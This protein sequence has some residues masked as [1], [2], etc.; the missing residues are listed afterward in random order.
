MTEE[1]YLKI[2]VGEHN[3]SI[4]LDKEM[5]GT[6]TTKEIIDAMKSICPEAWNEN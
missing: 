4:E 6:W 3:R 5:N 1:E 2:F